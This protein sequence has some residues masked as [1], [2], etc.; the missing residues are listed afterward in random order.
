MNENLFCRARLEVDREA[1]KSNVRALQ[2]M[3]QSCDVLGVVKANAYGVGTDIVVPALLESGVKV[4]GV[5]TLSEAAELLK[6]GVAIS[7]LY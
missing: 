6:Y 4:L 5:A 1:I 3:S 2:G 7:V